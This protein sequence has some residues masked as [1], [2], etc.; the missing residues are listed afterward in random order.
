MLKNNAIVEED[1]GEQKEQDFFPVHVDAK[2]LVKD[3]WDGVNNPQ[4]ISKNILVDRKLVSSK[5]RKN[6]Q[7]SDKGYATRLCSCIS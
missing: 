4:R 6:H 3:F 7:H 5:V 2:K 1:G